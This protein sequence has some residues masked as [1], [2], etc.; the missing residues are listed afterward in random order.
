MW[1]KSLNG[2]LTTPKKL[3]FSWLDLLDCP[4]N[5]KT[6]SA[7]HEC[8]KVNYISWEETE[9]CAGNSFKQLNTTDFSKNSVVSLNIYSTIVTSLSLLHKAAHQNKPK[10]GC[11]ELEWIIDPAEITNGFL[12]SLRLKIYCASGHLLGIIEVCN[13]VKWAPN[14]VLIIC[15]HFN[16]FS[17][18]FHSPH[19]PADKNHLPPRTSVSLRRRAFHIKQGNKIYDRLCYQ[20]ITYWIHAYVSFG[21]E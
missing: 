18:D 12:Q 2:S 13:T 11:D 3:F 16:P 9:L 7:L 20:H 15:L 21:G 5:F 19:A 6:G 17:I 8:L 10:W 14:T 4:Y 1:V